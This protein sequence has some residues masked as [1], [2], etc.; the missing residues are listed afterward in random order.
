MSPVGQGTVQKPLLFSVFGR[1]L[2]HVLPGMEQQFRP[3][4]DRMMIEKQV[5]IKSESLRLR[6]AMTKGDHLRWIRSP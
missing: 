3:V 2:S 1:F 5:P 6:E 4:F